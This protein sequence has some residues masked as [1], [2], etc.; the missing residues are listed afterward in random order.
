MSTPKTPSF[1]EQL[2]SYAAVAGATGAGLLAAALPLHA[3]IVYTPTNQIIGFR[4]SVMIDFNHDGIID[5]I[6]QNTL[7]AKPGISESNYCQV[8]GLGRE[9]GLRVWRSLLISTVRV[10][11]MQD[12]VPTVTLS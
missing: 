4:K 11:G 2:A 9:G 1:A 8:L 6:I 10:K 5:F 7:I 12:A 3:K